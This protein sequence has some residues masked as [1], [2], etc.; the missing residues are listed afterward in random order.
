MDSSIEKEVLSDLNE[1]LG[2]IDFKG[3]T[4]SSSEFQTALRL[5]QMWLILHEMKDEKAIPRQEAGKPSDDIS[6]EIEGAKKYFQKYSETQDVT[7]KDMA[8]DELR[9]AT[10]LIKKAYSRL[11]SGEEK[12]RLKSYEDEVKVIS[13]MIEKTA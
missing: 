4:P 5:G 2:K 13:S 3:Y 6:E 10:N 9:H 8:G 11:P 7:F 1:A 12:T